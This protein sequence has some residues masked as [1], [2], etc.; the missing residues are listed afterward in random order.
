MR[1]QVLWVLLCSCSVAF[2]GDVVFYHSG[3]GFGTIRLHVDGV[4]VAKVPPGARVTI[5]L[6]IG[7]H[8]FRNANLDSSAILDVSG[9]H[10]VRLGPT[11]VEVSSNDAAVKSELTD[12][13]DIT[14]K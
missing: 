8:F 3:S 9:K 14:G 7:R 4:L 12:T 10:L 2:P 13:Q 11:F 6:S 1:K 5:P